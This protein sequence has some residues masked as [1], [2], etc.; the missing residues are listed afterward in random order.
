MQVLYQITVYAGYEEEYICFTTPEAAKAI[1]EYLAYRERASEALIPNSPLFREQFDVNDLEQIRRK[2]KRI[3]EDVI[4]RA[5]AK[6]LT[7]CLLSS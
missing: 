1:D 2:A 5:F 7:T 6:K 4:D 3:T